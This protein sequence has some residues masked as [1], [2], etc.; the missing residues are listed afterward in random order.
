MKIDPRLR[1][2]IK[3]FIKDSIRRKSE[4]VSVISAYK[5]TQDEWKLLLK[6]FP[7]LKDKDI[8]EKIEPEIL[9]GII[10]QYRSKVLDASLRGQVKNLERTLHELI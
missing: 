2:S 9:A 5:L 4:K 3:K 8:V 10:I 1:E 6:R 7:F